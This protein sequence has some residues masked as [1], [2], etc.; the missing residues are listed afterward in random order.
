GE[1]CG[2]VYVR[3][4][5]ESDDAPG[6]TVF[7]GHVLFSPVVK[8]AIPGAGGHM[9]IR[10]SESNLHVGA[11]R[12]RSI[13]ETGS[14]PSVILERLPLAACWCSDA[15][16]SPRRCPRI[17]EISIPGSVRDDAVAKSA[18]LTLVTPSR[19]CGGGNERP[20]SASFV[21]FFIAAA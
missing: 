7:V 12:R 6:L 13:T 19:G 14:D 11:F 9:A 4:H 21:R 16:T 17:A 18:F 15:P 8:T 2:A 20:A 3:M 5:V 1:G 10:H